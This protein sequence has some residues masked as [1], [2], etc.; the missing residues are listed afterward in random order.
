MEIALPRAGIVAA[1]VAPGTIPPIQLPGVSQ[2]PPPGF[3]HVIVAGAIRHSSLSR[4][5][6]TWRLFIR[7]FAF[8]DATWESL[9]DPRERKSQDAAFMGAP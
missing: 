9:R 2:S 3:I 6:F 8:D 7:R 1:S 4:K 5:S